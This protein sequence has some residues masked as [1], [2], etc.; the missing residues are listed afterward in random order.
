MR[1]EP[2]VIRASRRSPRASS[3]T[4]NR[5]EVG[6]STTPG[7]SRQAQCS[8]RQAVRQLGHELERGVDLLGERGQVRL[9]LEI[10]EPGVLGGELLDQRRR[11]EDGDP[12]V[13]T[14]LVVL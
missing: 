5:T 1:L 14:R 12:H 3:R 2:S 13:N 6:G 9:L 10:E 4:S 11:P 8:D 7:V